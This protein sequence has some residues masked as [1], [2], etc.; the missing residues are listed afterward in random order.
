MQVVKKVTLNG[1]EATAVVRDCTTQQKHTVHIYGNL[2]DRTMEVYLGRRNEGGSLLACAERRFS[3]RAILSGR[4]KYV[5][6]VEPGAD[7]A[8]CVLMCITYDEFP[9]N[10][11]Q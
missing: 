6:N 7:I 3:R 8:M 9:Y 5:L 2:R 10:S 11:E 4:H 1:T